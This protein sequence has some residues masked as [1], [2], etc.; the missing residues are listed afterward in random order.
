LS[1]NWDK[2]LEGLEKF[3]NSLISLN[4][5]GKGPGLDNLVAHQPGT[6]KIFRELPKADFFNR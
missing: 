6:P 4:N 2:K 3:F 5:S 1:W